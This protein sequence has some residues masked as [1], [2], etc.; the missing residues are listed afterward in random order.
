MQPRP[1]PLVSNG[2]KDLSENGNPSLVARRIQHADFSASTTLRLSPEA[3]DSDAGLAALQHNENYLFLGVR[4]RKGQPR[5]VFMER[6]AI[7]SS[8]PETIATAPL[9]AGISS[10]ELR[11]T[12][13]KHDYAFAYRVEGREWV[14]LT[15]TA[16]DTLLDRGG[17]NFV[18]ASVGLYTRTAQ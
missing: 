8:G 12:G 18:G 9:P 11:L 6:H 17:S 13:K 4:V 5:E 1:V 10:I 16:D 15:E 2:R 7:G 14:T 3:A